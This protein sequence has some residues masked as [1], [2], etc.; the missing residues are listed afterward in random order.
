MNCS[1][2]SHSLRN[3]CR[4]SIISNKSKNVKS[5]AVGKKD[6]LGETNKT[7]FSQKVPCGV[8]IFLNVVTSAV[9]SSLLPHPWT[10]EK[11]SPATST[12]APV[13]LST[14]LKTFFSISSTLAYFVRWISVSS[15]L[16][17]FHKKFKAVTLLRF[18]HLSGWDVK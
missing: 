1:T 8:I 13:P 5:I 9:L 3:W 16:L 12:L 17:P 6:N 18:R 10:E 2:A 11:A 4:G 7:H 15:N 14:V